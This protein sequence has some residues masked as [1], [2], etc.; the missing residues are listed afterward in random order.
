MSGKSNSRTF[1]KINGARN[2]KNIVYYENKNCF[3]WGKLS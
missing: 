2:K 1:K 3:S